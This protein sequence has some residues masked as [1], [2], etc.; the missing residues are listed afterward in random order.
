MA[1]PLNREDDHEAD[2]EWNKDREKAGTINRDRELQAQG[3]AE[4]ALAKGAAGEEEVGVGMLG[5]E[6][7]AGKRQEERRNESSGKVDTFM[8]LM[9]LLE[10]LVATDV[11]VQCAA[12]QDGLK[13]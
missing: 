5:M 3:W 1:V 6:T 9:A 13:L 11:I 4:I 2:D 12:V 7:E 10:L 8:L